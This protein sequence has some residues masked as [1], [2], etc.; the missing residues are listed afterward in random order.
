MTAMEFTKHTTSY[1]TRE[2][3]DAALKRCGIFEDRHLIAYTAEGRVTAVFPLSNIQDGN[4]LRYAHLGFM[5][6]G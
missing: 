1:K 4:L 2:N 6:I 5:T 3:L